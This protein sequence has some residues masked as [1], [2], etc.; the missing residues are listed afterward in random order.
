MGMAASAAILLP[1]SPQPLSPPRGFGPRPE[2]DGDC[3]AE[4]VGRRSVALVGGLRQGRACDKLRGVSLYV[5]IL[6]SIAYRGMMSSA[7]GEGR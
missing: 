1:L 7:E 6:R 5:I 2:K 3:G 4:A